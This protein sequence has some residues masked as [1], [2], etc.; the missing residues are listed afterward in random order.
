[1]IPWLLFLPLPL[2]VLA[3]INKSFG[4]P[5]YLLS[6]YVPLDSGS[7]ECLNGSK[8]IPWEWVNDDSC[9]CPDGSDEPGTGACANTMFY[10]RNEGHIGASIPSSR[11]RDG[12]CEAECCDGS[13]ELPG[14]CSNTCATVGAEHRKKRAEELKIQKTGAKIRS[15]YVAFAHKEKKRLENLIQT[16]EQEIAAKEKEVA[17]LQEIAEHAESLSAADLEFKK[18]SP[19]Y[20]S[21]ITHS[22]AL[23]SL[24]REY[25]K[26]LEREETLSEILDTLRTNY[27]PNYQDMAVLDAVRGWEYLAGLPHINDVGKDSSETDEPNNEAEGDESPPE[28]ILEDGEWSVEELD[29]DLDKLLKTKHVELLL[30][31]DEYV[32]SPPPGSL[33]ELFDIANYLPD[34]LVPQ[35]EDLKDAILSWLESFGI[36]R[37]EIGS[38]AES[39]HARQVFTDAENTLKKIR[40]DKE[41]A[42]KDFSELFDPAG[43]GTEGEWKKLDGTCLEKDTGDYTYEVCLFGTAKQKPNK[44][45][46]TFN[47]GKFVAWNRD[48]EP[49]QP[50]YYQKQNYEKGTKCWNGPERSVI[51]VMACGTENTLLTVAE[52]EKCQY[53][54]TGTSPA[55]CLPVTESSM[56]REEL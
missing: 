52:L 18:Q 38:S 51:L 4:V 23:K 6:R 26:H 29:N 55:L 42:E 33:S 50:A 56:D 27:N 21:L 45:G 24:Q 54:F 17:R 2:P 12:L 19:L 31:H 49:G 3:G 11:V 7:W 34:S 47:L 14:V 13:D 44:G 20:T 1:M 32:R 40:K 48:A 35:Y 46:S 30:E 8:Q 15:S 16:S 43:F 22:N 28:E 39:T 36:I 41:N 10:C 37:P 5:P 25:K 53:Q 9:D